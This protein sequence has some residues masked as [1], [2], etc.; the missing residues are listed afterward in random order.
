VI[1]FD[2]RHQLTTPNG[3]ISDAGIVAIG[4]LIDAENPLHV[5]AWKALNPAYTANYIPRLPADWQ[6]EWIVTKGVYAG[7]LPKRV[8]R[9]YFKTHAL[10]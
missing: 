7:T 9:Y 5:E 1:E 3:L 8:A 4:Q 2:K 10:K 6:W